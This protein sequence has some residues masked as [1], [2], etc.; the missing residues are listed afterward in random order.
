MLPNGACEIAGLGQLEP[1]LQLRLRIVSER[2]D[3]SEHRIVEGGP[4]RAVLS[5]ALER[6]LG[7]VHAAHRAIR[8]RKGVVRGTPLRKEGDGA[9][10]MRDG[11]VVMTCGRRDATEP[12]LCSRLGRRLTTQ[13]V[14]QLLRS[15]E[16]S[17][18][19]QRFGQ[20]HPRGQVAGRPQQRL[21]ET[22]RGVCMSSEPLQ[23]EPVEVLPLERCG[24]QRLCPRIGLVRGAPLIPRVQRPRERAHRLHV[25]RPRSGGLI[26]SSQSIPRLGGEGVQGQAREW[27]R[28]RRLCRH[29][30]RRRQADEEHTLQKV[31]RAPSRICRSTYGAFVRAV[32]PAMPVI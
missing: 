4:T 11:S 17:G 26:G 19:E 28:Q 31:K 9:F 20:V 1:A 30:Q 13:R 7:I 14:E 3:R 10:Q 21:V 12:E 27:R 6:A 5:V 16:V 15:I 24:R 2:G 18:L 8:K 29:R 25:C 32:P 23:R 22:D